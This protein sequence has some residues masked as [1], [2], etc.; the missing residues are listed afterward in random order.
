MTRSKE[1]ESLFRLFKA[2][3]QA[4]ISVKKAFQIIDIDGSN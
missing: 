4:N 2:I 3:K 1:E